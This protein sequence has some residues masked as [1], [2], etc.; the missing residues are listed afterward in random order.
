MQNFNIAIDVRRIGNMGNVFCLTMDDMPLMGTRRA[1]DSEMYIQKAVRELCDLNGI[2]STNLRQ[3]LY[4]SAI[5]QVNEHLKKYGSRALSDT[6]M[7]ETAH[8]FFDEGADKDR[9]RNMP[10]L[11]RMPVS[12]AFITVSERQMDDNVAQPKTPGARPLNPPS[13]QMMG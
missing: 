11:D 8:T 4:L 12:A 6:P 3:C 13:Q 2:V 1:T 10:Q 5:D 9:Y 7:Q